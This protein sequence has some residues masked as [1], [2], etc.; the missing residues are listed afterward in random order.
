VSAHWVPQRRTAAYGRAVALHADFWG[1]PELMVIGDAEDAVTLATALLDAEPERH[2]LSAPRGA[3]DRIGAAYRLPH[4]VGWT[5]RWTASAPALA[6]PDG[7]GWLGADDTDDLRTLLAEAFPDASMPVGHPDV[8]RWA[9]LRRDGR[10]VACAADATVTDGVGFLASIA[11]HPDVRGTGA[12]A[13]VTAWATAALVAEHGVC[14]LWH[15]AD[16]PA[17]RLYERLGYPETHP[18]TGLGR[19]EP[20]PP[21][22]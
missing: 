5:F 1:D 20:H 22:E 9:G 4:R 16:N 18:M 2:W 8:R 17:A 7:V 10:L 6:L 21:P 11:S 13:A 15:M 19:E 3:A 14:G 12:G